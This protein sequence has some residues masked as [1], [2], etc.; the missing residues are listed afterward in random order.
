LPEIGLL[1][2]SCVYVAD[3]AD[4]FIE[5]VELA[6]AV[7]SK[8][9]FEQSLAMARETWPVKIDLICRNL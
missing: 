7:S 1:K 8:D 2:K 3:T 6:L 5:A 4:G 9:R